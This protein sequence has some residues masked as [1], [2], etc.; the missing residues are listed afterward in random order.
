MPTIL[1]RGAL[2]DATVVAFPGLAG[3]R[4]RDRPVT[5]DCDWGL[6]FEL[7]DSKRPHWTAT[8]RLAA[9]L[10]ALRALWRVPLGRS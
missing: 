7:K 8:E 1:D 5:S 9:D 10:R 6:G 4:A 3:R 2:D